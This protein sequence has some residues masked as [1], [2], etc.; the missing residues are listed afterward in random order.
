MADDRKVG[1]GCG[2]LIL[3]ALIVMI[4]SNQNRHESTANLEAEVRKLQAE[5][6]QLR[7]SIDDQTKQLAQFE[8]KLDAEP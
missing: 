3:I 1:L 8:E 5:V 7:L 2:T 6:T 4:F